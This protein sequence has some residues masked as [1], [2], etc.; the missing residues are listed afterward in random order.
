MNLHLIL[1]VLIILI[2]LVVL[3]VVLIILVV[4]SRFLGGLRLLFRLLLRLFL[5]LLGGI[6]LILGS[7][8]VALVLLPGFLSKFVGLLYG[9]A[10]VDIV[11]DRPTVHSPKLKA[12]M[13]K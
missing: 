1:L 2:V 5:F 6:V 8:F 12:D 11:K 9:I 7:L 13:G 3:I 4:L 10:D